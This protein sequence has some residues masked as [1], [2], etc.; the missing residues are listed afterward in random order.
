[1]ITLIKREVPFFLIFKAYNRINMEKCVI[2]QMERG[3]YFFR[4][5]VIDLTIY[6]NKIIEDLK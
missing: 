2:P 6:I 5:Y 1:M 3:A 4:K